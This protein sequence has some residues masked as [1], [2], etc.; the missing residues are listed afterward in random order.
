VQAKYELWKNDQTFSFLGLKAA[1]N[2]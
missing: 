1:I 2:F